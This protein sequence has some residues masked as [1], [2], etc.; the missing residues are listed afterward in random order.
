MALRLFALLLVLVAGGIP[1]VAYLWKTFSALLS[2]TV[3]PGRLMVAVPLLAVFIG[4]LVFGGRA[5]A[6][7]T[8]APA[9]GARPDDEPVI[10]G[11]LLLTSVIL[12]LVFGTWIILY[13][14]LLDR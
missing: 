13:I 1:L 10:T 3:E 7:A 14:M 11:T 12:M 2:G 8:A 6:R 9:E 4:L 5:L